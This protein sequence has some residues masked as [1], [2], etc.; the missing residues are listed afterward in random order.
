MNQTSY[1]LQITQAASVEELW[2]LYTAIMKKFGFDRI[3]YGRTRFR[4]GNNLG[5]PN[6]YLVLSNHDP[7]YV[8]YFVDQQRYMDS[9]MFRWSF[10]NVGCASWSLV[11]DL[12][13]RNALSPE[14]I[15]VVEGNRAFGVTAGYT[16]SFPS[17]VSHRTKASASLSAASGV[18]QA[19]VDEIWRQHG[20][21]LEVLSYVFD[22]KIASLPHFTHRVSLTKRQREVLEW[23]ADGKSVQDTATILGLT[24]ATVEKHLRLARE[25]LHV[26]TTAQAVLK[27]AFMNQMFVIES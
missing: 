20:A 14:E 19:Q 9:P 22:L 1:L 7:A 8:E 10:D 16:I 3:I 4:N 26:D 6:D 12:A 27:A 21:E 17:L 2:S 18:S 5:D 25:G 23:I 11:E 15:A 24:P 13:K